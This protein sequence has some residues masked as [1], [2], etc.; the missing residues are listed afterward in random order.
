[1]SYGTQM[2]EKQ[3][4]IRLNRNSCRNRE[5]SRSREKNLFQCFLTKIIIKKA[6]VSIIISIFIAKLKP[7][8]L[9][10][11][12][13][14][15]CCP[16]QCSLL[17]QCKRSISSF[18]V[19]QHSVLSRRFAGQC[20]KAEGE[21]RW[22]YQRGMNT[23]IWTFSPLKGSHTKPWKTSYLELQVCLHIL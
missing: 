9:S 7:P 20:M 17:S 21:Y 18:L 22:Q 8:S 13:F 5:M 19:G 23:Q 16:S 2:K 14:I 4:L 12:P 3:S 15:F 11:P 1:M 6:F 10:L